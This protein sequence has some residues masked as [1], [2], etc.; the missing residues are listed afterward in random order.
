MVIDRGRKINPA[1]GC[2]V[3]A[4][5]RCAARSTVFSAPAAPRRPW[6][7]IA[8][9]FAAGVVF[10]AGIV[11]SV[12]VIT[13]LTAPHKAAQPQQAKLRTPTEAASNASS[14]PAVRREQPANVPA[15]HSSPQTT[16]ASATPE[17]PP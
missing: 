8:A 10:A 7:K 5:G 14:P 13:F 6:L 2:D 11:C 17:A 15:P 16:Q 12:L 4:P 1:G 3:F 9:A